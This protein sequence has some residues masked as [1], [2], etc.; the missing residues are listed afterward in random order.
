MISLALRHFLCGTQGLEWP[1]PMCKIHTEEA[2]I[3]ERTTHEL[4][5]ELLRVDGTMKQMHARGDTLLGND[6]LPSVDALNTVD[7]GFCSF[8]QWTVK[9]PKVHLHTLLSIIPTAEEILKV[10]ES[11]N[12]RSRVKAPP[13]QQPSFSNRLTSASRK[14]FEE[15][16][17]IRS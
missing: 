17:T 14:L 6:G 16:N 5:D 1:N 7:T 4:H 3:G 12:H 15:Y 9:R 11:P 10:A 8:K 13:Q 2:I